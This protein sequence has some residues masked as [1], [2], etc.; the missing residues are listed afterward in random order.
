MHKVAGDQAPEVHPAR[1]DSFGHDSPGE[2][3][4]DR[5]G[6]R[7]TAVGTVNDDGHGAGNAAQAGGAV[8]ARTISS[9]GISVRESVS[10]VS[11]RI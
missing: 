11:S 8:L 10:T 4:M 9:T 2:Q 6:P 5:P 3:P 7:R 1:A